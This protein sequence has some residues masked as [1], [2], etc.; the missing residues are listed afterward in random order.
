MVCLQCT[1]ELEATDHF[2]PAC[3]APCHDSL[4]RGT[5]RSNDTTARSMGSIQETHCRDAGQS[6]TGTRPACGSTPGATSADAARVTVLFP[7]PALPFAVS[8]T[9]ALSPVVGLPRPCA[10]GAASDRTGHE[11][12]CAVC[13]QLRIVPERDDFYIQLSKHLVVRSHLGLRHWR[14]EDY[15]LIAQGEIHGQ[16]A[17]WFVV[18]DGV[19]S[20]A[21]ADLASK[22]ACHA[23]LGTMA[24]QLRQGIQPHT[25]L[26]VAIDAAQQAVLTVPH[27]ARQDQPEHIRT[28][29]EA[30]IVL[31]LIQHGLAT[32]GWLGDSRVYLVEQ[33]EWGPTARLLTRDHSYINT[34]VDRGQMT[35]EQALSSPQAH[36]ITKALGPLAH[37]E[38]LEPSFTTC[39][40]EN[41][42]CLI[43]CSDGF[44]RYAHPQQD[45]PPIQITRLVQACPEEDALALAHA[46]ITWANQ[47]GGQDN[48]TVAVV[49]LTKEPCHD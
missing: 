37:G 6:P 22:A 12:I 10:C 8:H 40:L 42:V 24:Q 49:F 33:G 27:V 41:A 38:V 26:A 36:A 20:T 28:P 17:T 7:A 44:W 25:A 30:T 1:C 29:P 11:G 35:R 43:G 46:M 34:L 48:I 32:I 31:C 47:S 23:A 2:C 45:D 15:G 18:S 4:S 39:T 13:G 5:G 16:P 3:G 19:S 21:L 9:H 14:N